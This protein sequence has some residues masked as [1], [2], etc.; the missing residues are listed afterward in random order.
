[1]NNMK[2][3][4]TVADI[5]VRDVHTVPENI[6]L[7]QAA[8]LLAEH[9]IRHLIVTDATGRTVGVFSE[10]DL[11]KHTIHC[12]SQD[13]HPG[14]SI[15]SDAMVRSLITV[16]PETLLAHAAGILA[17]WKIGCLPVVDSDLRLCGIVSVVDVLR[18]VSDAPVSLTPAN[19]LANHE[20]TKREMQK[21]INDFEM[22]KVVYESHAVDLAELVHELDVARMQAEASLRAKSDFLSNIS[23][24]IRTPMTA[25]LG[26]TD[27]LLDD[28][29]TPPQFPPYQGGDAGGVEREEAA[30]ADRHVGNVSAVIACPR[31]P[32]GRRSGKPLVVADESPTHGGRSD[33]RFAAGGQWPARPVDGRSCAGG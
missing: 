18:H 22:A 15:V 23:H 5:M 30:S 13:Q 2:S 32:G 12:L 29:T 8:R 19:V 1:M 11:T 16:T 17:S 24:E 6:S 27:L 4:T 3:G 10:R 28:L 31:G 20:Q 33:P 14:Y 9:G 26:F 25:I 7:T 21:L